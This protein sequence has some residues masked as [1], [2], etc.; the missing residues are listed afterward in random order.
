MI[1]LKQ[2]VGWGI[3]WT[4][5]ND[6]QKARW[7]LTGMY[8]LVFFVLLN[9]FTGSL[10]VILQRV[11][12]DYIQKTETIWHKKQ[13][14]FSQQNITVLEWGNN[15]KIN[16]QLIIDLHHSFLEDIRK[17]IVI[18]EVVLL[19]VAG[20]ASYWLSGRTLHPIQQK[21]ELQK[22]F[23]ADVSHELKNPLSALK[24]SLEIAKKQKEWG[25][26]EV[27]EI[28]EDL[29]DEV[30]RLS[31]ITQDLLVLE[32]IDSISNKTKYNIK[33][34]I[35]N[36]ITLLKVIA[37]KRN[38]KI[39]EELS[40]F[41]LVTN[42]KSIEQIVF[43]LVH[44]AIKF[45]YPNSEIIVKLTNKGLLIIEDGG[46]GISKSELS[47]IFERFYKIDSS[48][49]FDVNTGSGLGL[50]I[51]KKTVE[52]NGWKIKVKSEKDKGTQFIIQF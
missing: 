38:I 40:D 9:L 26:G 22:Q 33:D 48:R 37:K 4:R 35:N 24:T 6:Y 12:D 23:L 43:N 21:N 41:E 28:F 17:W 10:F 47:R 19:C 3:A 30:E 42:K 44:N 18:I 14:I 5:M 34:I 52:K 7:K 51:V 45:S 50:A 15:N 46:I 20:F 27:K 13:I 8:I 11:E 49:T 16:K 1:R 29:E 39:I 2:F 31:R 36:Q 25:V 32:N